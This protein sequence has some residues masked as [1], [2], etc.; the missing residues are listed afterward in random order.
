MEELQAVAARVKSKAMVKV[1]AGF[2]KNDYWT[3][4][5]GLQLVK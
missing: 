2:M 4:T 5:A 3:R 1:S